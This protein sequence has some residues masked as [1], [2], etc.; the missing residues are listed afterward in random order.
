MN[1]VVLTVVVPVYNGERYLDRFLDCLVKQW[2]SHE[3]YEILCINDGSTDKSLEILLR[4][5]T[6]Y[7]EYIR[8]VNQ[9]NK[10]ILAVRNRGIKET[11]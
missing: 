1:A 3:G 6:M 4:Y 7:P 8:I 10:G 2:N 11:K 9:E 5:A